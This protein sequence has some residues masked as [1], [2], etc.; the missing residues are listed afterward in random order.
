MTGSIIIK[1]TGINRIDAILSMIVALFIFLNAIKGLK[2]IVDLFL[3]KTPDDINV[4]Q[5][6]EQLFLISGVVDVHHIHIWSIDGVNNFA[7]MHVVIKDKNIEKLKNN[8][9]NKLKEY[10]INHSTIEIENINYKCEDVDC[11]IEVCDIDD[12]HHH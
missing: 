7:T 1:F 8:I 9:K 3:E 6:K 4:V 10:G 11:H 12:C 5:L 2:K